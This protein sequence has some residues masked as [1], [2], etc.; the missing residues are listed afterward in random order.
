MH[1]L[2]A[3]HGLVGHHEQDRCPNVSSL[4]TPAAAATTRTTP[5]SPPFSVAVEWRTVMP[6]T[7]GG[8]ATRLTA[9]T[10]PPVRFAIPAASST[11]LELLIW[12]SISVSHGY[13]LY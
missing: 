5:A 4:G 11:A 13:L 12:S 10:S 3:V 1:D 9:G 7:W 2:V 8:I 6:P